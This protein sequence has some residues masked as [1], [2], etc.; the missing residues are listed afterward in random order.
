ME[1][2]G[3]EES[4]RPHDTAPIIIYTARIKCRPAPTIIMH[5][6]AC[7]SARV[8][9]PLRP[10]PQPLPGRRGGPATATST[11][12]STVAAAADADIPP[13]HRDEQ[14]KEII[15]SLSP[16]P[17]A[18]PCRSLPHGSPQPLNVVRVQP[19]QVIIVGGARRGS[20]V[21]GTTRGKCA[22]VG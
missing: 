7:S 2:R 8:S 10:T 3:S 9:L 16:A 19:P 6:R 15:L 5:R 14:Q 1:S 17:V 11:A 22:R 4:A 13:P 21:I 12:T 20:H 18:R